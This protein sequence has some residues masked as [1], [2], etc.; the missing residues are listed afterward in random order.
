MTEPLRSR[1]IKETLA[2]NLA[3]LPE[4]D[5]FLPLLEQVDDDGF[6]PNHRAVVDALHAL[7]LPLEDCIV[8][9]ASRPKTFRTQRT[10]N[11]AWIHEFWVEHNT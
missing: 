3:M 10:Q 6:F 5:L 1:T 11:L 9:M 7:G 2:A 4:A 8:F